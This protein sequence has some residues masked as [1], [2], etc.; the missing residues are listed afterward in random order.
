MID[1][2]KILSR[3]Y[4]GCEWTL[5]GEDYDGLTWL[6]KTPKPTKSTLDGLW[7]EVLAELEA[8]ESSKSAARKAV[9][10]KL[11]VTAEEAALLL[12]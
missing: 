5:N 12:S 8:E 3:K 11:G 1:Y 6:S 9:L 7:T 2:S 10:D 4:K